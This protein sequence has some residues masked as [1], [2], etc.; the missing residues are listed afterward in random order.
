MKTNPGSRHQKLDPNYKFIE[1]Y[2]GF[3]AYY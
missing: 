1:S 2:G 3:E